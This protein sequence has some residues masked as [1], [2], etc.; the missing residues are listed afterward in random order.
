MYRN[1]MTPQ[2]ISDAMDS[3]AASLYHLSKN[4]KDSPLG[5]QVY[6]SYK[7]A[8]SIDSTMCWVIL[9]DK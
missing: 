2:E 8:L 3:I 9:K 6:A 1:D 4:M 5:E 7:K